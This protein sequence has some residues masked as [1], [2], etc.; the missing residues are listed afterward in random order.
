MIDGQ[1]FERSDLAAG[2]KDVARRDTAWLEEQIST[3]DWEE[4]ALKSFRK[5]LEDGKRDAVALYFALRKMVNAADDFGA[6]AMKAYGL[7]TQALALAAR[8]YQI[9]EGLTDEQ[10]VAYCLD[11]VRTHY[12]KLGK[13]VEIVEAA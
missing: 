8:A 4:L 6:L 13:R 1:E 9:T 3:R 2:L 12:A 10:K 11:L 5:R 7:S